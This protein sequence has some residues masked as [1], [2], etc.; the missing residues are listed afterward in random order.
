MDTVSRSKRSEIM[1]K[2]SCKDTKPE[3]IVRKA[4]FSA[5]FRYRKNVKDLLGKPDVV[6]PKYKT[7]IFVHGCFWHGHKDC[8]ASKLP[9]S[10]VEYWTRKISSNIARD[11]RN[12]E[13]LKAKGWNVV[14]IWECELKMYNRNS[15]M[16]QLIE[17][18]RDAEYNHTIAF[19]HP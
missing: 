18:I 2:V 10:N 13:S 12:I 17:Q 3:I 16:K 11:S 5:G 9:T 19:W 7:V 6:L 1:S 8:E 15:R 4:L 14:I